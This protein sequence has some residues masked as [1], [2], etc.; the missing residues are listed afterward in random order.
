MFNKIILKGR[1]DAA[2]FV[3]AA[4]KVPTDVYLTTHDRRYKVNGKSTLGVLLALTEWNDDL[5]VET[6]GAAYNLLEKFIEV[7]ND[8]NASIHE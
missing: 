1:K 6:D 3:W 2:D 5:W 4:A 7:A 8:D